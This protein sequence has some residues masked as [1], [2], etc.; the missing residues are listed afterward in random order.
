MTNAVV[1]FVFVFLLLNINIASG[2]FPNDNNI[3]PNF[4]NIYYCNDRYRDKYYQDKYNYNEYHYNEYNNDKHNHYDK[5]NEYDPIKPIIKPDHKFKSKE[6]NVLLPNPP[7]I[8]PQPYPNNCYSNNR[9]FPPLNPDFPYPLNPDENN[10]EKYIKC[11]TSPQI[12]IILVLVFV[13][14][15]VTNR[16]PPSN[17]QDNSN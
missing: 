4:N 1:I 13:I 17:N 3:I 2:F 5:K 6:P 9:P 7:I 12:I 8:K 14:L 16:C 11:I 10:L 15:P